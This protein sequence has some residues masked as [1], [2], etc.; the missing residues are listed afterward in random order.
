MVISKKKILP[1][2]FYVKIVNEKMINVIK[3]YC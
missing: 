3:F 2:H 1:F